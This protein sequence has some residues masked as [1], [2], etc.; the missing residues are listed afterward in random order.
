MSNMGKKRGVKGAL[1]SCSLSLF[2]CFHFPF[3]PLS[4]VSAR[5]AHSSRRNFQILQELADYPWRFPHYILAKSPS[6]L[7]G[8]KRVSRSP[9]TE[10]EPDILEKYDT[11][12]R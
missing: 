8:L 9:A 12:E 2:L 5:F 4:L 6:R 3:P 1:L 10:W 7:T 11:N